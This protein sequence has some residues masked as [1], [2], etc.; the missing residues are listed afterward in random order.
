MED[1]S[2][3]NIKD[4][5]SINEA[6]VSVLIITCVLLTVFSCVMYYLKGDISDNLTNIIQ[7]IILAICGVNISNSAA[8][9]YGRKGSELKNGYQNNFSQENCQ[10]LNNDRSRGAI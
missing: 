6:K 9:A 7:T 5:L 3:I 4:G 8:T 10:G 2:K 1:N